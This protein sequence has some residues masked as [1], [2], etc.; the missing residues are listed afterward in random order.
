MQFSVLTKYSSF[1]LIFLLIACNSKQQQD[2]YVDHTQTTAMFTKP[3]PYRLTE[4]NQKFKLP[5]K[6]DEISG[7][8]FWDANT[9]ACVQDEE[10]KIFFY[11]LQEE[12]I[13]DTQRFAKDGDFEDV[14][15]V[16]GLIYALRSD[17]R[18]YEI[19]PQNNWEKRKF[20]TPLSEG[21]DTEG[22]CYDSQSN[23]LLIGCKEA[24]GIRQHIQ[25]AKGVYAFD[26]SSLSLDEKPFFMIS[27]IATSNIAQKEVVF[28]P[29]GIAFHPQTHDLYVISTVG[30]I[31]IVLDAAGAIK[32]IQS[33]DT[34]DFKQPEGICFDKDGTLYI[35]N[36]G[37][38]GKANI[39]MF[40][41]LE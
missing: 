16:N 36:E 10:G 9:L 14:E 19:D 24:S 29:S 37:K 40:K 27:E 4:P 6:L 12:Q 22:L 1:L 21:N 28:K 7:I 17:G 41:S 13:T 8:S 5:N 26:L 32:H 11:N 15:V 31:L 34:K 25:D 38:G 35:S 18:I 23:K 39:L 3:F 30:K 2:V 33:L 20:E